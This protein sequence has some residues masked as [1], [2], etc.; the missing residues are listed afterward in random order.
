MP[1]SNKQRP[2]IEK[3]RKKPSLLHA[4]LPHYIKSFFARL[5]TIYAKQS[6]FSCIKARLLAGALLLV[7]ILAAVNF[8]KLS[9][10]QPPSLHH[11]IGFNLLLLFVASLSLRWLM[12]GRQALAGSTIVLGSVIPIYTNLLFIAHYSEPLASAIQLFAFGLTFLLL[13]ILFAPRKVAVATLA[14][15][16]TSQISMYIQI[17]RDFGS[18]QF[19]AN[20]LLRDGLITTLFAF[21]LGWSLMTMIETTHR[22]S[23]KALKATLASKERLERLVSERTRDLEKASRAK[24]DFL[25]NM[26]HEIRT[27]LN[28]IIATSELLL[29]R[30]DLP[31]QATE[32]T[33]LIATSGELLLNLIGDILDFSKIEVGKLQLESHSF[34]LAPLV[35]DIINLLISRAEKDGVH[36]DFT[37]ATTLPANVEGDSY[38]LRQV[39]LN[40]LSNAIKFTPKGGGV[41]LDIN[42]VNPDADPVL[43]SFSVHDTGIGM[44]TDVLDRLFQRFSQADSSTTRRYGGSGLGLAISSRLTE[45]MGG[46]LKAT[47]AAGRGSVFTCTLPL[48]RTKDEPITAS[49]SRQPF[50][51]LGLAV[52][53]AEDN[54]I[55]RKILVA[56]LTQLGCTCTVTADGEELLAALIKGPLPDVVLMDCHMPKLDGWAATERLRSWV[57]APGLSSHQRT[58]GAVPVIALTAAVLSQERLRC[59]RSGMN[60]FLAKP[61][62]LAELCDALK[63]YS[64]EI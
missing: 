39:L 48:R 50:P 43:V 40:L 49:T 53:V 63:A 25:A 3:T 14:I 16:V 5:D 11:R 54:L 24:G 1:P 41:H 13:A 51:K 57:T 33:R 60:G 32:D 4:W 8:V 31:P 58:A 36:L 61:V 6:Y 30:T 9:W 20:T 18:M 23:D 56:Q 37:L 15:I 46:T 64:T 34:A 42:A 59:L 38:R 45:M 44:E 28:G 55:N 26:S 12:Q 21:G 17:D 19:A 22:R 7:F 62:K 29:Q 2:L 35:Q 52:L 47:S 10:L 27:P